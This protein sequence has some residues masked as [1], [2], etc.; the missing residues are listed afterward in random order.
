M[1]LLLLVLG[2]AIRGGGGEREEGEGELSE[3]RGR[4]GRNERRARD[5]VALVALGRQS[6]VASLLSNQNG[7]PNLQLTPMPVFYN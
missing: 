1:V 4:A 5:A 3:G 6:E 7:A 2:G